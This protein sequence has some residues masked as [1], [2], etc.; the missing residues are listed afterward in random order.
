MTGFWEY[1]MY[2]VEGSSPFKKTLKLPLSGL[3]TLEG[4]GSSHIDLGVGAESK[5]KT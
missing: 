3:M 2:T 4:V 5:V 1:V